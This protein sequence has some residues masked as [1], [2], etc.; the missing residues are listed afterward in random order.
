M[1]FDLAINL[2]NGLIP[3]NAIRR[4]PITFISFNRLISSAVGRRER[5]QKAERKDSWH[6]RNAVCGRAKTATF[7]AIERLNSWTVAQQG[8]D[9]RRK[10]NTL[11]EWER[12]RFTVRERHFI[13]SK[14]NVFPLSS[15]KSSEITSTELTH[16]TKWLKFV[17]VSLKSFCLTTARHMHVTLVAFYRPNDCDCMRRWRPS[18]IR[19]KTSCQSAAHTHTHSLHT[20]HAARH[21]VIASKIEFTLFLLS[22]M[23]ARVFCSQFHL[24]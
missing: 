1:Y 19:A 3:Q 5:P 13:P 17:T 7:E 24:N 11:Y 15:I 22:I 18:R 4:K 2:S 12:R 6:I 20:R 21:E 14:R 23:T 16:R 10:F 9:A 8:K